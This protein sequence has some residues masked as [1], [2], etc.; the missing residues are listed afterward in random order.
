MITRKQKREIAEEL[1]DFLAASHEAWMEDRLRDFVGEGDARD[2]MN[3]MSA[4]GPNVHTDI[5]RLAKKITRW[6]AWI[7]GPEDAPP[8][9]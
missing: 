8:P 6:Y 3:S 7:L 5:E 2:I 1:T 9:G 4:V